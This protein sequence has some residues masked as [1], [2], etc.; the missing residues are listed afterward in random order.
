MGLVLYGAKL[1]ESGAPLA[2]EMSGHVFFKE[3]W[4][5]FDDG[6][7][8][9]ARLLEILSREADP[10]ALLEA[11]PDGFEETAAGYAAYLPAA[12]PPPALPGWLAVVPEEVP[13]GW[14][15][16]WKAFHGPVEIAGAWLRPSWLDEP[17]DALVLEVAPRW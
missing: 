16:A 15:D 3:R 10:S 11:L 2:G 9:A 1:A 7:Y 4:Y 5:G 17:A 12:E 14:R 8:C 6:I 13:V